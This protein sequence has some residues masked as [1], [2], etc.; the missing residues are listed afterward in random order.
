MG[1][2]NVTPDSFSDGGLYREPGGAI[3]H[4]LELVAQGAAIVDVGGESTRPGS[5][6]VD[7]D[8]EMARVMPVV[9]GLVARGVTVSIDTSKPDVASAALEAGAVVLNDVNGLREPGMVEVVSEFGCGVVVMHMKGTPREMQDNPTYD[10]VV[11]EVEEFLLSRAAAL[12]AEGVASNR[13]AI[14][15]G[16]G[17]G[18]TFDHNLSLLRHLDRLASHRY[19][20][21]L[22]TSRKSFL[23]RLTGV[24]DPD[25]RDGATAISTAL[26]FAHGA[27]VFRVHDVVSS[28]HALQI[29]SAIVASD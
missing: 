8:E 15:P 16:I 28:R 14:D 21:V 10:D 19:P 29:A 25:R 20:V 2:L 13:I 4:G 6:G 9:D 17:F 7:K 11:S 1:V 5:T 18:K 22:G 27:R 23:G 24:D 12:E 26:G 3:S